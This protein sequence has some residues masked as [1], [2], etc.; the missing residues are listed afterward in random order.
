MHGAQASCL[1]AGLATNVA[2]KMPALP[3]GFGLW[4]LV[5]G[6]ILPK[7]QSQCMLVG[8][9]AYLMKTKIVRI[10]A[11]KTSNAGQDVM[12][13]IVDR[14]NRRFCGARGVE[15][16]RRQRRT[17]QSLIRIDFDA[18][19]VG[20]RDQLQ[21]IY[22]QRLLQLVSHPQLVTAVTLF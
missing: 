20:H 4:S 6:L 3:A 16:E 2:G 22:K 17:S 19:R 9:P 5:L 21:P 15:F 11:I 14:G 12:S 13:M 8:V 1:P 7:L 18:L 10:L